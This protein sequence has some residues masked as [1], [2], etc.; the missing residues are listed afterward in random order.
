MP[1]FLGAMALSALTVLSACGGGGGGSVMGGGSGTLQLALTD[2]PA[3]G[4]D[5]VYVTLQKV[6]VHQSSSAADTDAGWSEIT[7]NPALRVD[8][9]T[10]RNGVLATL[11]S[12]PLAAGHYTQMR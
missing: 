8:L 12:T 10:L 7:L 6:R 11:G 1:A 3:C 2:A 9:L 4:F 5:K